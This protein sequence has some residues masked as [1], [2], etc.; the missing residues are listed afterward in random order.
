MRSVLFDDAGR[1]HAPTEPDVLG[2]AQSAAAPQ[3][4]DDA[5]RLAVDLGHRAPH[6][7][8][9]PGS[10]R[11]L[12]QTLATLGAD[13]LE[14]CRVVEPHLDAVGILADAGWSLD[15]AESE[16]GAT[17]G[18]FAAEGGGDRLRAERT[19]SGWTLT[20]TKPWCS[21][22]GTLD[23]ALITAWI[24]DDTRGLFAVRLTDATVAVAESVWV[25]RGLVGI[26]S[27][28][29]TFTGTAAQ[30]IG[31]PGWYLSRPGFHWGGIGVAAC[32]Y[33]GAVGIARSV[34]DALAAKD[35]APLRDMH[36]GAIDETLTASRLALLDAARRVDDGLAD[37]DDGRL[38][39]RR[40][41]GIVARTV[42]EVLT[43]SGHALGPAP[44]ALDATH[45][46]RVADLQLYVR[47][48]HAEVDQASLGRQI[49]TGDG[50]PW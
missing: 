41:R 17:W 13:D 22:A 8:S 27:G 45:A 39:A 29:V 31:E 38:L 7:G 3:T 9:G 26:P 32:W 15:R 42:E 33:G 1:G 40:V 16:V 14:T 2:D 6:A 5:L 19:A 36:V 25:A 24:D 21:L 50:A 35:A 4:I 49:L 12:W 44:L 23:A 18:V 37:G 20:G 46:Q 10:T 30:P 48:H 34:V 11:E 28:P 47:Q 43:R